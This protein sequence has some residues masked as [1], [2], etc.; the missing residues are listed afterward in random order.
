M[1]TKTNLIANGV[2]VDSG[3]IVMVDK[4]C[5]SGY[6]KK[7]DQNL[8]FKKSF[9][10][11]KY[12]VKWRI[13]KTW[14]G[15]VQGEETIN[16]TSGCLIVADPCYLIQSSEW[17]K[18]L[19]VNKFNYY[20][21]S[22]HSLLHNP[23]TKTSYEGAYIDSMGGDGLYKI[24]LTLIPIEIKE[25]STKP[26]IKKEETSKTMKRISNLQ[27][28]ILIKNTKGKIFSVYFKK[29]DGSVRHMTC[30]LGVKKY[31][32]GKGM[33]WNPEL[34]EKLSVFDTHK[35]EYRMINLDA[36]MG[37][38]IAGQEYLVGSTL[39]TDYL[40]A[41]AK[42]ERKTSTL[43]PSPKWT[44]ADVIA[45]ASEIAKILNSVKAPKTLD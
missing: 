34:R 3:I 16:L 28:Y 11:G 35:N 20:E 42:Q 8:Y 39:L 23:I 4:D 6:N 14:N 31:V 27:A 32:T 19:E 22:G 43:K 9:A 25:K 15:T 40:D 41:K 45:K 7:S 37:L 18:W 12:K 10:P 17:D 24:E 13:E 30:R 21:A 29:T 38:T 26:K 33:S 2:Y 1:I 36:L 44:G 5:F